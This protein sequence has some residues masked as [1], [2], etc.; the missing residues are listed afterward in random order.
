MS[1]R[2]IKGATSAK[3]ED[4]GGRPATAKRDKVIQREVFEAHEKA[5][6][7]LK[8][9]ETEAEA[10]LAEASRQASQE[11]EEARERG[12]RDGLAKWESLTAELI[13]ARQRLVE[14]AR[15]QIVDLALRA[16]AKI[17]HREVEIAPEAIAPAIEEAIRTLRGATTHSLRVTVHP[18]DAPTVEKLAKRLRRNDP[19]W[20]SL[21]VL[22]EESIARGGCR[23][24]SEYGEIDALVE[25]QLE[26]MR[27]ILVPESESTGEVTGEGT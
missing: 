7:I 10:L 12:H 16:A 13:A 14:D 21:T 1:R 22:T 8:R 6:T 15:P 3:Q 23:V 27:R 4:K 17:L 18:D 11:L 25:T 20:E 26:A 19:L 2:V 5:R 24:T 9:A